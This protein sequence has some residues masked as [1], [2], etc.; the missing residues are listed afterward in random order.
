MQFYMTSDA[1][2]VLTYIILSLIILFYLLKLK[3]KSTPARL[4]ILFF[5]GMTVYFITLFV[6]DTAPPHIKLWFRPMQYLTF[7]LA[8]VFLLKFAYAFPRP[9]ESQRIEAKTVFIISILTTLAGTVLYIYYLYI[10]TSANQTP[11]PTSALLLMAMFFIF[12]LLWCILV[13][14]R[15]TIYLSTEKS[16]R[17]RWQIL[18]KPNG[19]LAWASRAFALLAAIPLAAGMSVFLLALGIFSQLV[20]DISILLAM[21]FFYFTSMVVYLNHAPETST[22]MV[23]LVGVSLVIVMVFLGT[24]TML[25]EPFWIQTSPNPEVISSLQSIRFQPLGN[26]YNVQILPTRF[27]SQLGQKLVLENRKNTMLEMDFAFPFGGKNRKRIYIHKEGIVTFDAPLFPEAF[28]ANRQLGISPMWLKFDLRRDVKIGVFQN[29]GP[30]KLTIT[31][32]NMIEK[33]TGVRRTLQLILYQDGSIDF[34]YR[35]IKGCRPLL[36][37]LFSG[38][39]YSSAAEIHFSRDLPF[40]ASTPDV[41]QNFFHALRQY[42]H[43]ST[44]PLAIVITLA[45][46]TILAV[47]PAF[48]KTT[49]VNP[50]QALLDGVK[51]VKEGRLSVT[52]PVRCNDEI[53]FLTDSFNHMVQSLKEAKEGLFEAV[54]AKDELLAINKAILDTA[55]EGILT[56]DSQ[57]RILSFN[58]AAEEMFKYQKDEVINRPDYILLDQSKEN[59]PLGFLGHFMASGKRKRLGIKQ[60][61]QGKKKDGQLFPLEFAVSDTLSE[62]EDIYTVILHDFSEHKQLIE[63]KIKL[64]EQ[65]HQSQKLETIGTLAG[66]IAHDFNNILTPLIGY[67]EMAMESIPLENPVH[68]FLKNILNSSNRAKDLVKQILSFSRKSER[69]FEVVDLNMIIKEAVKLLRASTPASITFDLNLDANPGTVSGDPTQLEQVLINL[70]TNATHA[71][72]PD[73]GTLY[74]GLEFIRVDET[75]SKLHPRLKED[76][77]VML[78]VSDTGRGMD[79]ETLTHI[80]EPFFTTKTVGEGTGL[81]L[82]VVHG[83]VEKHGGTILVESQPGKGTNF[84]IYFPSIR[85]EDNFE[86]QKY[87]KI[88]SRG[89]GS[90][91]LVDDEEVIVNMFKKWLENVGYTVTT[92][93]NSLKARDTFRK[94]AKNFDIVITD[95][96]MPKLTGI[97]LAKDILTIRPKTPIILYTGNTN[98]ISVKECLEMG[99]G[100]ILMKPVNLATL[101]SS[102]KELLEHES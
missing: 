98:S 48:F 26:G 85:T 57:G 72:I 61:F 8:L 78:R 51:Q 70:C 16:N 1:T 47:F 99:V 22:F 5:M 11:A 3:N 95:L 43:R 67:T 41:F 30:G 55:A 68:N 44:L 91:L 38:T 40:V 71:M 35:D 82:S 81:G 62:G 37:G 59:Q 90:I 101:N 77:Y 45:C 33:E 56:L 15:R 102:I 60:E 63:E 39:G 92:E 89:K 34:N 65:L 93:T 25:L 23:K 84:R 83:T 36:A 80:F 58:K 20:V 24:V 52:I 50:L 4:L 54:K 53:G 14:L 74:I 75:L 28:L 19:K 27:D 17:S 86:K 49:L 64:E 10:N 79:R 66:G 42:I 32:F 97:Q 88:T 76:N 21:T 100:K 69:L 96:A 2:V 9:L 18:L 94:Q 7:L 29:P 13:F 6:F 87:E 46:I 12:E 73:G 31:W